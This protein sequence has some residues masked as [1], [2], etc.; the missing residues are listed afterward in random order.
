MPT[1]RQ[2]LDH[3]RRME[4]LMSFTG[5]RE[6]KT[7]SRLRRFYRWL[8]DGPLPNVLMAV[9]AVGSFAVGSL[10]VASNTALT[11][12]RID[13]ARAQA[14][15]A[16]LQREVDACGPPIEVKGLTRPQRLCPVAEASR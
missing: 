5:H 16:A 13:L 3:D 11:E 12:A 1:E 9:L 15:A 14:R 4:R 6:A 7:V 8:E 2:I 10:F